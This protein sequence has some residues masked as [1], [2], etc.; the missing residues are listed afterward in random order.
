MISGLDEG[1]LM[2]EKQEAG[3]DE[4]AEERGQSL[5]GDE[6][7]SCCLNICLVKVSPKSL[8]HQGSNSLKL[9]TSSFRPRERLSLP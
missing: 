9:P 5:K 3:K 7:Q 4:I 6:P 1:S 2:E 8:R